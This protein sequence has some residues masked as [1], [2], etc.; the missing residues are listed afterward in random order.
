MTV[1]STTSKRNTF[2]NLTSEECGNRLLCV[3]YQGASG[4]ENKF[5][6]VLSWNIVSRNK[7][8]NEDKGKEVWSWEEKREEI[9]FFP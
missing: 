3:K 9:V 2:S 5:V 1:F 4:Y 6:Q 8:A 7:E